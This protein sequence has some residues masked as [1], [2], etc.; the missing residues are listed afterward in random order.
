MVDRAAVAHNIGNGSAECFRV[1]DAT[2]EDQ[3]AVVTELDRAACHPQHSRFVGGAAFWDCASPPDDSSNISAAAGKNL[4]FNIFLS[5]GNSATGTEF[6]MVR[7]FYPRRGRRASGKWL[8]NPF[9]PT[10][11]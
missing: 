9:T 3:G 11:I 8:V 6:T 4:A 7:R 1:F 2:I 5:P 10:C